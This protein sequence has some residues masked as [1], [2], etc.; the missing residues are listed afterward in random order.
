MNAHQAGNSPDTGQEHENPWTNQLAQHLSH[1]P[2]SQHPVLIT[3]A[4]QE[5]RL[6]ARASIAISPRNSSGE[7][8]LRH[9]KHQLED[10]T[11]LASQSPPPENMGPLT[12]ATAHIRA[13]HLLPPALQAA[14]PTGIAALAAESLTGS[15]LPVFGVMAL[16]AAATA[17]LA[18]TGY[19]ACQWAIQGTRTIKALLH[20]LQSFQPLTPPPD[21]DVYCL[22]MSQ[23]NA[24]MAIRAQAFPGTEPTSSGEEPEPPET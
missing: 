23:G 5:P 17:S 2:H 24:T 6:G 12:V 8:L 1:L 14:V 13:R 11:A 7:E 21:R 16:A 10:L 18:W 19:Q 4:S 22:L 3:V 9:S 20:H 15:P